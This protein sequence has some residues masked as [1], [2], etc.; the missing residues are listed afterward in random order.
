[1][2]WPIDDHHA[3]P[4]DRLSFATALAASNDWFFAPGANG[5]ELFSGDHPRWGDIT[6]ELRLYD[7]GT[8]S[9]EELDVGANVGTQQLA[10]NSGNAD[11]KAFVRAVSLPVYQTPASYHIRATL[12]AAAIE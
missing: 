7:L 1:M 5:I 9:D 11:S 4:G 10:P 6:T 3:E 2:R 12:T 8:E